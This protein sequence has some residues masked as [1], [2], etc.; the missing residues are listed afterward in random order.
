MVTLVAYEVTSK[1]AVPLPPICTMVW[2]IAMLALTE[3]R[4]AIEVR[5]RTSRTGGARNVLRRRQ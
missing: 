2:G 4:D 1:N 5:L 3:R